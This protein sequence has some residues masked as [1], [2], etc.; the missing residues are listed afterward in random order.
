MVVCLGPAKQ[1]APHSQYMVHEHSKQATAAMTAAVGACICDG[2]S[3]APDTG[4]ACGARSRV[5]LCRGCG[6]GT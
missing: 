5:L 4:D 1:C 6:V 3:W 2:G